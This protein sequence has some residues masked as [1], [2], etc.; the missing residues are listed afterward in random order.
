MVA[1]VA[2]FA[3]SPGI[4]QAAQ[5]SPVEAQ[6]A[7]VHSVEIEAV[8]APLAKVRAVRTSPE[9]GTQSRHFVS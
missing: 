4:A 5:V 3:A 9:M 6:N 1:F 7:R 8:Q 2:V